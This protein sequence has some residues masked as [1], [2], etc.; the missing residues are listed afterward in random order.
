MKKLLISILFVSALPSSIL[1]GNNNTCLKDVLGKYFLI[2]TAVNIPQTDGQDEKGAK[3]I[4]ENF[5]AIVA[6]NCMKSEVIQPTE[7]V[8]NWDGADKL[9]NF[10]QKNGLTI[11][12]HCLI[13]HSQAPKW[14]F[15]DSKGKPVSRDTLIERMHKHIAAVVGR[16]KGKILGWDVVNEAINDNG[17]FRETPFYKIIGSDYIDLAFKFAHE[18]DPKAELYYNDYSMSNPSRRAAVCRIIRHLKSIGCRIDAVGMQ[19]HNGLDYPDLKEYEASIDSFAN[20]GVKVMFTE[21]DLNLLPNPA[22]FGGAEISQKYLYDKKYNPYPDGLDK[23]MNKKFETR[24]IDFFKIY[25]KH[26]NQISRVTLWG[27]SDKNTWLND[28]PIKGRSNYPL[29]FDRNYNPKPVINKI[30]KLFK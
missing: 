15:T 22:H 4:T 12:G 17:T 25:K 26:A 3:I 6:E 10:G 5:N 1:A 14:F 20:C 28:W 18:A 8:F 30:I 9:V 27:V 24:Y 21:L 13:W 23:A 11:T 2:G 19:S 29:L 16:Y 7:N